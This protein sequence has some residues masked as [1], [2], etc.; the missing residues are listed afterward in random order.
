MDP[1]AEL[2][3][4]QRAFFGDDCAGFNRNDFPGTHRGIDSPTTDVYTSG[5]NVV[6]EA[7]L[8]NFSKD[9]IDLDIDGRVLTINASRHSREE[10][11]DRKYVIRESSSSFQRRVTLPEGV[12][13]DAI[14]A[15][16]TDGVLTITVPTPQV[17]QS[18]RKIEITGGSSTPET[19]DGD[20]K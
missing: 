17:S 19:I 14:T 18:K 10:D 15:Q 12:D 2:A 16:F 13:T 9:D 6:V 1:F 4:L 20:E 5:D 7:H 3:P 8:P 11:A